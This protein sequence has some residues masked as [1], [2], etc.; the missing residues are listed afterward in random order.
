[1]VEEDLSSVI[2]RLVEYARDSIP[3]LSFLWRAGSWL[4][5]CQKRYCPL[6]FSRGLGFHQGFGG[7][8]AFW[9]GMEATLSLEKKEKE[10]VMDR[11]LRKR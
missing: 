11:V 9:N 4:W 6:F 3:I 10:N 5:H 1:M 2:Y 7:M 8:E